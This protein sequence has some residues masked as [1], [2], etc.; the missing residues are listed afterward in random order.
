MNS[1]MFLLH[2]ALTQSKA[3]HRPT[4]VI[5]PVVYQW[6]LLASYNGQLENALHW[7]M[8]LIAQLCPIYRRTCTAHTSAK[9]AKCIVNVRTWIWTHNLCCVQ[10]WL[11]LL[12]HLKL[13]DSSL[14]E[15]SWHVFLFWGT[16]NSL[17][18]MWNSLFKPCL[19]GLLCSLHL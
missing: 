13:V 2:K 7:R 17:L 18:P 14:S 10:R 9:L 5:Q 1:D 8:D 12:N 3:S 4:A 19:C 11:F 16:L 6:P 15:H